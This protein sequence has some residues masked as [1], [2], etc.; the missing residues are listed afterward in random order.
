MRHSWI[1]LF[2]LVYATVLQAAHT[3]QSVRI[4]KGALLLGFDTPIAAEQI[5]KLVLKNSKTVRYVFDF[6]DTIIRKRSLADR[7]SYSSVKTF[8]ISQFDHHTVRLVIE[9]F[10]P[11][12]IAH[13][14]ITPTQYKIALPQGK[15]AT[16]ASLSDLFASIANSGKKQLK[17]LNK[18]SPKPALSK[19]HVP[20][21][22]K[23][24]TIVVD[25]GHGGKDSGALGGSRRYMEKTVVLQIAKK[26]RSH[27]KR[28][29]FRVYMTRNSNRFV[30]LGVRT[31]YANR[32]HADAFVSIHANAVDGAKKYTTEGIE[33]Y[34]LQVSR[35]ARSKR[36]AA[37]ENSVVRQAKDRVSR[38]VLLNLMTG[39]KIVMSNKMAIDI[40][41]GMLQNLRKK[42]KTV[43][44]NGVRPAPFWVLVGAQMPS[45][46]VEVGY[47]THS[48][49]KKRL[50]DPTYQDLIAKGI[51]EGIS[52]YFANRE[53]EME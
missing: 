50:F 36:V 7:L 35:S 5:H 12:P 24:Y 6:S 40:Q 38:D 37:R 10:K 3:L 30:K 23:R 45:V 46:L 8:R 20:R 22:K 15:A 11:Y 53:K 39:P 51:A 17:Q 14:H 34:Y 16:S 44:D 2:V 4:D 33:T 31:H 26:V 13:R 32:K 52:N 25:P 1:F 42:F 49:E 27:L 47:I 28:L 19:A 29:G 21:P 48:R 43:K 9:V 18:K 41:K